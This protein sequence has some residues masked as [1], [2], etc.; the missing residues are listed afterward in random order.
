L[1]WATGSPPAG[2]P[3][4]SALRHRAPTDCWPLTALSVGSSF[5]ALSIRA[6][7]TRTPA[8]RY[9]HPRPIAIRELDAR[10]SRAATSFASGRSRGIKWD[11]FCRMMSPGSHF[12]SLTPEPKLGLLRALGGYLPRVSVVRAVLVAFLNGISIQYLRRHLGY[13][14]RFE[15]R[16]SSGIAAGASAAT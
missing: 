13:P 4:K 5:V 1:R 6:F 3:H 15:K 11:G 10:A 12:S 7:L 14:A 16:G 9:S 2:S 8:D